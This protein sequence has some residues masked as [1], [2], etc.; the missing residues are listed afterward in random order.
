M[1]RAWLLIALP[2]LGLLSSCSLGP[3]RGPDASRSL[4][5][6]AVPRAEAPSRS[7]NPPS[8]VVHGKRYYVRSDNAGYVE[9]GVASWYGPNFHG[10]RT[11]SGETYDMYAM[12][13]AHKTLLLPAYVEVTNL[14]N[15][16]KVVVRVNDRGPFHDNRVIDLSYAAAKKL[17][18]VRNGT[19]LVEVRVVGPGYRPGTAIASK[20]GDHV[21]RWG[22]NVYIQVGAFS[23]EANAERLRQRLAA[24]LQGAV[25]VQPAS[26]SGRPI[27]KV[28]VGPMASV[29]EADR[30]VAA[31]NRLGIR[32]L[33]MVI[34]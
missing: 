4:P 27:Y 21:P 17:D 5:P 26:G 3:A 2:L 12:T 24:N 14:G 7:G 23:L 1:K 32:D 30:L 13:A 31:L 6:D 9:R 29:D 34:D 16:R 19:G 28:R 25:R 10:K 11:S 15:G 33:H 22:E 20:Q 8:Y 18:I